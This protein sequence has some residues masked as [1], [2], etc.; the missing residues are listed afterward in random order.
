M[1]Q[2]YETPIMSLA[3]KAGYDDGYGAG[4]SHRDCK[5]TYYPYTPDDDG[6]DY[7][8]G[9]EA[10]YFNGYYNHA[11]LALELEI[12]ELPSGDMEYYLTY[13]NNKVKVS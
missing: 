6:G 1:E 4:Q 3:Y 2:K 5:S 11:P 13:E 8:K 7:I 10:G 12:V 9:Y